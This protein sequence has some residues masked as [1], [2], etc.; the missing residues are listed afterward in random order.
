[1]GQAAWN[2]SKLKLLPGLNPHF[3][4]RPLNKQDTEPLALLHGPCGQ[5]GQASRQPRAWPSRSCGPGGGRC[6]VFTRAGL[7]TPRVWQLLGVGRLRPG[8]DRSREEPGTRLAPPTGARPKG[9]AGPSGLGAQGHLQGPKGTGT[10]GHDWGE[11][12]WQPSQHEEENVSFEEQRPECHSAEHPLLSLG[13]PQRLQPGS[14]RHLLGVRAQM[15]E[16]SPPGAKPELCGLA[17]GSGNT[18]GC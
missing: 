10:P 8:R 12:P 6:L 16:E 2:R 14:S 5:L 9:R 13:R 18:L 15:A 7:V 17:G 3:L 4:N 1:M 11:P